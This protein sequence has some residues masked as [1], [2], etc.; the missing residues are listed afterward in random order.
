M[1]IVDEN[2]TDVDVTH[3]GDKLVLRID[4]SPPDG[5]FFLFYDIRVNCF[6]FVLLM[7][8]LIGSQVHTT[9]SQVIS[10]RVARRVHLPFL[11]SMK[12]A[13]RVIHK[14]FQL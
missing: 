8:A 14:F 10:L 12:W 13:A 3:V 1:R 11:C 2:N 9:L 5:S 4:I 7:I 6:F